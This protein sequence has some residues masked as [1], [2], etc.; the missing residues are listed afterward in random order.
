MCGGTP[1]TDG[2]LI[3]LY[4]VFIGLAVIAVVLRLVARVLTQA[5]F[6]WDDL[7][8][9]FGF[10]GRTRPYLGYPSC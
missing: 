7:S 3:P 5:Y 1:T 6:W 10:V 9:L 2:S 8:N 4:S